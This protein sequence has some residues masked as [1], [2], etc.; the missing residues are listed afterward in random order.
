MVVRLL[1]EY[2]VHLAPD[3]HG[4]VDVERAGGIFEWLRTTHPDTKFKFRWSSGREHQWFR[5]F[6]TLFK[7]SP[8][9]LVVSVVSVVPIND[10]E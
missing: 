8:V 3:E 6:A 4:N 1:R 10:Q 5:T 9:F 2:S 7:R